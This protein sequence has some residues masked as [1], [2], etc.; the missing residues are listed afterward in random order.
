MRKFQTLYD[1][2][3]NLSKLVDELL[4]GDEVVITRHGKPIAKIVP[5]TATVK[6][7]A[8]SKELGA[9]AEVDWD[10]DYSHLSLAWMENPDNEWSL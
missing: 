9:L 5:L 2:K 7:G 1:A 8:Y 4:P 10:G 3:T 6:L